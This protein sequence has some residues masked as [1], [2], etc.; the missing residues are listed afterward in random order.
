MGDDQQRW[1]LL[2]T[3]VFEVG[4]AWRVD[5]AA[6]GRGPDWFTAE[7]VNPSYPSARLSWRQAYVHE[8]LIDEQLRRAR[9]GFDIVGD[10]LVVEIGESRGEEQIGTQVFSVA[11]GSVA[12]TVLTVD[13]PELGGVVEILVGLSASDDDFGPVAEEFSRLVETIRLGDGPLPVNELLAAEF[14]DPGA[15]PGV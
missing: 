9:E 13:L 4:L 8:P 15:D 3:F 12:H 7:M 14:D 5:P 11:G 1:R 10:S 6:I 2:P